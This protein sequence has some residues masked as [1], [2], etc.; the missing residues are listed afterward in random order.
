MAGVVKYVVSGSDEVELRQIILERRWAG[1]FKAI[2]G[3]PATKTQILLDMRKEL[4]AGSRLLMVGDAMADFIAARDAQAGFLFIAGYSTV[5]ESMFAL[6]CVE[7]FPVVETLADLL[8]IV[9]HIS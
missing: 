6:S 8:P 1:Y 2:Y 4:P 5:R 9:T 7:S 3:S